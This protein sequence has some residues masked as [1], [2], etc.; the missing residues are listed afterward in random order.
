MSQKR[1]L[2][3]IGHSYVVALNRRLVN[4]IARVGKGEWEVTAVAPA[5]MHGDLRSLTFKAD[6]HDICQLEAVSV[7]LS[8]R[9][10][11]MTYGWHLKKILQQDWD[12]VHCWEE[13]YILA[14]GQVAWWL[15]EKVPLVYFTA[16][17]YFKQYPPPFNWIE[18]CSMNRAAGWICCGEKIAQTLKPR[19]GYATPMKVIPHGVDINHFYPNR[20]AG[21]EILRSLGW[22]EKGQPVIGY[23]GRFIPD[24]GLNLL[25]QVLDK[26]EAPWR[27]MFVGTG[28]MES[29]LRTWAE[30]YPGRVRICTNVKHNDVPQ[31]LNAMDI[32]CAPS[33]TMPN[34]REQFGRML[35]EAFACGIPVIGSDSGEIPHVIKDAGIVV[36][37]KDELGWVGAISELLESPSLRQEIAAKGLERAR[38]V[39]AWSIVARQH[40]EFFTE[41]LDHQ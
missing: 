22:E 33:Q 9:I 3:S 29:S 12:L 24:K 37:E 18:N 7:N 27:A 25:M 13:P 30:R 5:F 28:P 15:P 4:E 23:L 34:W 11:F 1:K 2:L 32:L 20:E 38:S 6:S 19:Q 36:G 31:Y 40:L 41:I 16:Q 35:V 8:K 21:L 10:H 14:G 26:L 17:S 39:Y